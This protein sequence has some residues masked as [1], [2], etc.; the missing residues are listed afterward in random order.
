M[1][2]STRLNKQI[3]CAAG[4]QEDYPGRFVELCLHINCR[5]KDLTLS[6]GAGKPIYQNSDNKPH[7]RIPPGHKGIPYL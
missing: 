5:D 2:S 6:K 4:A 7:T 3:S 1:L